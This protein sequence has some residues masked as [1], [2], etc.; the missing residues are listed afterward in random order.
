MDGHHS[1]LRRVISLSVD[2][3][4]GKFCFL[5]CQHLAKKSLLYV[6]PHGS[7]QKNGTLIEEVGLAIPA[8]P[9]FHMIDLISINPIISQY[10]CLGYQRAVLL[11]Y[12]PTSW[13]L[14]NRTGIRTE[15]STP[16]LSQID[17]HLEYYEKLRTYNSLMDVY[18]PSRDFHGNPRTKCIMYYIQESN[19]ERGGTRGTRID[20]LEL[21]NLASRRDGLCSMNFFNDTGSLSNGRPQ[22]DTWA[23]SKTLKTHTTGYE[24]SIWKIVRVLSQ[25]LCTMQTK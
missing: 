2:W 1:L 12:V 25:R 17:L 15:L 16:K 24:M 18:C 7:H 6:K 4:T 5:R 9:A 23:S 19:G 22:R 20:L 13:V 14:P 3:Q 21:R 8:L 11:M 10:F